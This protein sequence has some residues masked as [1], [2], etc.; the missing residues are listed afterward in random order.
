MS[1]AKTNAIRKY[2]QF[3][4]IIETK[5]EE[6][7]GQGKS[8]PATTLA[9]DIGPTFGWEWPQAYHII[10]SY[11]DERPELYVKKGP[12]GGIALRPGWS[13]WGVK[14]NDSDALPVE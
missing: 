7:I 4:E 9:K 2:D 12:K 1:Q 14:P 5:I 10:N 8:L 11:L 13:I 3:C 6:A